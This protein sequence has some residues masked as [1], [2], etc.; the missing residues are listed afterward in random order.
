MKTLVSTLLFCSVLLISTFCNAGTT[1][2]LSQEQ[3]LQLQQDAHISI[4]DVR[5]IE[6][7]NDGHIPGAINI[8]H[9]QIQEHLEQLLPLKEQQVVVYCR[10][11]RRAALAEKAMMELGLKDVHHLE[12]DWLLW[13]EKSR[14]VSTKN[15]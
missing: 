12:G 9:N 4:I 10:S 7:F 11:G 15:E 2:Q 13:Q 5:S 6:E 1:P 14:P 8:P 3:L